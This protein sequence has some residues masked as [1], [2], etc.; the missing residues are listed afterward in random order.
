MHDFN[1]LAERRGLRR[2]RHERRLWRQ[3]RTADELVAISALVADDAR[4]AL[5]WRVPVHVIH[6]G[7]ADLSGMHRHPPAE[8]EADGFLL[9]VSR[10]SPSKNVE[11]LLAL[12][13][14]WPGQRFVLAGPAGPCV[15]R[16]RAACRAAGLRN[17][18][19]LTDVSDAEKAWLYA[20]CAGF[21]FP[22][23]VEGFGLPPLEAM[24]F[25][26]PVFV[27]RRASLPEVCGPAAVYID[28]FAPAALRALIE[29]ALHPDA[30]RVAALR[31]QARRFAW[32][33]ACERYLELY[34]GLLARAPPLNRS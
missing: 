32:G 33:E 10:M 34:A 25:G 15:E 20:H 4:R 31:A 29:P 5:P 28:E 17:V 6:N 23:I 2:W 21:L 27:A 13:A 14:A 11:A 8:P 30:P 18:R 16:H 19:F 9:H 24:C 3:L 7:V 12:A 22:S 26:K 1:Y